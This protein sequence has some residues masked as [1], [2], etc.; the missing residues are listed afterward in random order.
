[1]NRLRIYIVLFSF[2]LGCSQGQFRAYLLDEQ[3]DREKPPSKTSL[4][5]NYIS[6]DSLESNNAGKTEKTKSLSSHTH[7]PQ[8]PLKKIVKRTNNEV[9]LN[10]AIK[11]IEYF[12][13]SAHYLRTN[14][15]EEELE[16]LTEVSREYLQD[17]IDPLLDSRENS[18]SSDVHN[19][20]IEIKYYK[21]HL[22]YEIHDLEGACNTIS[23]LESSYHDATKRH[24]RKIENLDIYK[25]PN[26]V[27]SD[28]RHLCVHK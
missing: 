27:M 28:F 19:A 6:P 17:T 22:L 10:N 15:L 26:K 21:A 24:G 5:H 20:L 2:L 13:I 18:N 12:Y 8:P 25:I 4:V 7:E 23:D 16:M 1:M 14:K 3:P 9:A 11:N